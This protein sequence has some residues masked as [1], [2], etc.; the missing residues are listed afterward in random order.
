MASTLTPGVTQDCSSGML[1][2]GQSSYRG[3]D[4]SSAQQVR[5]GLGLVGTEDTTSMMDIPYC[6]SSLDTGMQVEL[7]QTML[8][9]LRRI[10]MSKTPLPTSPRTVLEH[11][12]TQACRG[13]IMFGQ[14]L[15]L[16]RCSQ[17]LHDLAQCRAPFQCA[18]GRPS[19]V[20]LC[21]AGI[22]RGVGELGGGRPQCWRLKHV[23]SMS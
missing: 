9:E 11:L 1:S 8:L 2:S 14:A 20:V 19:L 16:A 5:W 21:Q 10:T 17:L 3:G 18:H 15:P 6:F 12:G 13:A 7:C 4:T 22:A 23:S